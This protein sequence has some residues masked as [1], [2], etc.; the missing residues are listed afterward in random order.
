M[1]E[2]ALSEAVLSEFFGTV[3]PLLDERQ[4]RL[5]TGAASK[6]FGHGGIGA[7]ARMSGLDRTRVSRGAKQIAS[8]VEG[9]ARARV[10][11]PGAGRKPL[12]ESQ[13]GL[14]EALDGLVEPETRGDP[15]C[16]LRWTTK[17]VQNLAA[18]LSVLGFKVSGM[19]VYNMLR[20]MGYSLQ[21]TAKTLEGSSHPDRDDQFRYI[22]NLV[23]RFQAKGQPVTSCDAK[24][25]EKVGQYANAG[26]EWQPKGQPVP[27]KDHDFPDPDMPKVVPYGVYDVTGNQGWVS[28]GISA[29]TA[30]FAVNS[31]GSWW[32]R[33]GREAYP[34]ARELLITVD[35]G[36]SNGSRNRLWKKL[37]T[38]FAVKEELEITVCHFPPGTSKWNKIEHRLFS[39]ITMNWRGRP[40]ESYEAVVSLIASTTTSKGLKVGSALDDSVY[41]KGIKI[42]DQELA[43]LPIYPHL[44]HGDWNYTVGDSENGK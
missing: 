25:K 13:P 24:K 33:M 20:G 1:V 34:D 39:Q 43:G 26:R 19:T 44:F 18:A 8:G 21:G 14:D 11:A 42:G 37:I 4:A 15:M 27:V 5:V 6:M 32:H 36:G 40:L 31:I 38:E 2:Y 30:E 22:A 16:R 35:G 28:V 12:T 7:V 17:S 23:A 3:L 9:S 41:Q 10:R 29:D